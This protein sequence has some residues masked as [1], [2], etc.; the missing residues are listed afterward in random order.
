MYIYQEL[1]ITVDDIPLRILRPVTMAQQS[2]VQVV[3]YKINQ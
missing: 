1:F 2:V 3:Q